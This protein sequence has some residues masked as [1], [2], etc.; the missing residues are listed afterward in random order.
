[1]S[2]LFAKVEPTVA[3][4]YGMMLLHD[5][6]QVL[7]DHRAD[8]ADRSDVVT[9]SFSVSGMRLPPLSSNHVSVRRQDHSVAV[10]LPSRNF[11]WADEIEAVASAV[12]PTLGAARSLSPSRI[13]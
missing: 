2:F 4:T 3:E 8:A 5:F 13:V 6:E 9:E 10:R 12:A 11:L 7:A 1:M